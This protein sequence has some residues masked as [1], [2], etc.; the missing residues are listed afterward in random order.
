MAPAHLGTVWV[1]GVYNREADSRID[2]SQASFGKINEDACYFTA[3]ETIRII[4][5]A[6]SLH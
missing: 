4:Y 1:W 6:L 5:V 3:A 2:F